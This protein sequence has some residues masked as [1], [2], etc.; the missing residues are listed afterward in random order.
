MMWEYALSDD[1]AA[2]V[3]RIQAWLQ[4]RGVNARSAMQGLTFASRAEQTCEWLQRRLLDFSRSSNDAF[5]ITGPSGCG[6]S[7]LYDWTLERLQRP[8]GKKNHLVLAHKVGK[9][10]FLEILQRRILCEEKSCR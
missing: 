3:S 8:L 10:T 4:P 6:K 5:Y 2:E 7:T 1:R 9:L